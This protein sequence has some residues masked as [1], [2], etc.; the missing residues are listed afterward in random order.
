MAEAPAARVEPPDRKECQGKTGPETAGVVVTVV[1][2]PERVGAAAESA[3]DG[4]VP[5]DRRR[6][7]MEGS[8]ARQDSGDAGGD[9][10]GGDR[11]ADEETDADWARPS[12]TKLARPI[13]SRGRFA[14]A[15]IASQVKYRPNAKAP[16]KNTQNPQ[17]AQANSIA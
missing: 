17:H 3:A 14:E 6:V 4:V 16:M 11:T 12:P 1:V 13:M 2:N 9:A 15:G 8:T 5:A 7:A 10:D